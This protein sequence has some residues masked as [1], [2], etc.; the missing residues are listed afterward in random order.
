VSTTLWGVDLRYAFIDDS[1]TTPALA[2]RI[3]GTRTTDLGGL[4]IYT[5]GADLLLSKRLTVVTPYIGAGIVQVESTVSGTP[6]ADESFSK[7]RYFVGLNTNLAVINFAVEAER[8]G[9][10]T[11]LSAK[12][13][14]RF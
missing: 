5:Y 14:W 1:L 3:S 12:A 7:G 9:N 13:G 8:L 6:L 11:T 2:G 10:N 4:R